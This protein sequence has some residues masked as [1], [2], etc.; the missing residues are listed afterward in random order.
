MTDYRG[1]RRR[2]GRRARRGRTYNR[3]YRIEFHDPD[4]TDHGGMPTYGWRMA[5]EGLAT[6]RQ[7]L[8]LELRPGGQPVAAQ[9]LWMRYGKPAVA[10]LYRIDQAK[11]KRVPSLAQL[12]AIEKALAARRICPLCKEDAG[13]TIPTSLGCCVDCHR[14]HTE[15]E[16]TYDDYREGE[17][18]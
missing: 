8:A 7:L 17:A 11:P 15:H 16:D 14:E 5:P 3:R 9:V 1:P 4:G 6:K 12:H 13:Y 18:A 2:R 10:Y